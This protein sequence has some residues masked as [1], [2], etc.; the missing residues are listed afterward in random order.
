M[1]RYFFASLLLLTFTLVDASAQ[2]TKGRA[3]RK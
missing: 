1:L 3:A 2:T